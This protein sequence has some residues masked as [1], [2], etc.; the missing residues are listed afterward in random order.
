[1]KAGGTKKVALVP[2][3]MTRPWAGCLHGIGRVRGVWWESEDFFL[4]H[5]ILENF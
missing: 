4:V 1:L 5:A 2:A 3:M